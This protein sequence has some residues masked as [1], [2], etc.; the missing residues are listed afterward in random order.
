[1]DDDGF[2]L[3][4]IE[5]S[6]ERDRSL[7][8]GSKGAEKRKSGCV[9]FKVFPRDILLLSLFPCGR[10]ATEIP[11]RAAALAARLKVRSQLSLH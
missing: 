3:K 6:T 5:Q 11:G 8:G 2:R 7:S 9:P 10:V 4:S 1:M